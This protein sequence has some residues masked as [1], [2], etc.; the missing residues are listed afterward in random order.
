MYTE[1][2]EEDDFAFMKAHFASKQRQINNV[3]IKKPAPKSLRRTKVPL[4]TTNPIPDNETALEIA[5]VDDENSKC[6]LANL[7]QKIEL[8]M[9]ARTCK[10]KKVK[11]MAGRK[12][13]PFFYIQRPFINTHVY[14]QPNGCGVRLD[15]PNCKNCHNQDINMFEM[16]EIGLVC[17]ECGVLSQIIS[18]LSE[19]WDVNN[20]SKEFGANATAVKDHMPDMNMYKHSTHFA[21]FLFCSQAKG[22]LPEHTVDIFN[23]LKRIIVVNLRL[24][25]VHITRSLIKSIL[26]GMNAIKY[27]IYTDYFLRYLT[28]YVRPQMD[29]KQMSQMLADH[30]AFVKAYKEH[31]GHVNIV[32]ESFQIKCFC[33]RRNYHEIAEGYSDFINPDTRAKRYK[34]WYMLEPKVQWIE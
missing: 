17:T 30:I 1:Q 8:K 25:S 24:S 16:T 27:Y 31:T 11:S 4:L 26:A 32:S 3:P 22:P 29:A 28:G 23:I 33:N 19:S 21:K 18:L 14:T 13:R 7:L 15:K 10:L 34:L 9:Q 2:D 20:T 12:H 5:R 6:K